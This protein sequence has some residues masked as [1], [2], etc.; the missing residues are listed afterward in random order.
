MKTLILGGVKS[1]KS[2][3]AE[4]LAI[5]SGKAVTLIATARA[6]DD[7]MSE[8]IRRH[9]AQRNQD[10]HLIE[11]PLALAAALRANQ[12]HSHCVVVDC[13]TLWLTQLLMLDDSTRLQYEMESLL[14]EVRNASADVILIGNESSMGITPL[15]QLSREFCDR[16]G[17]LHQQLAECCDTVI[18]SIAGLPQYIK[19]SPLPPK[20]QT[21]ISQ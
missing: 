16:A 14:D 8:R 11:E 6:L 2:R 12:T 21:T 3:R 10:W 1:G 18:L 13:L 15:G 7:E 17:V 20:A 9:K 19:G 5:E 4:Q